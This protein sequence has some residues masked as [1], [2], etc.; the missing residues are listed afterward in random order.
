MEG[1][2]LVILDNLQDINYGF[3][4]DAGCYHPT[5]LNNTFLLYKKGWRGINIDL[6]EYTIDLFNFSRPKDININN[7]VI[8]YDGTVKFYYQKALS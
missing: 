4:V 8:N 2:D 3:F 5:H 7:A 1:E 6:S